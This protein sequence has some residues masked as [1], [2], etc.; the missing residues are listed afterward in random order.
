ML[1][2]PLE[3]VEKSIAQSIV[4]NNTFGQEK[5]FDD[6]ENVSKNSR[7][8][9]EIKEP[10]SFREE[11]N[12]N[13]LRDE[14]YYGTQ[15]TF[16]ASEIMNSSA[17]NNQNL[18][19]V[20]LS[21]S[22]AT[23]KNE[24]DIKISLIGRIQVRGIF[25]ETPMLI[26]ID[27]IPDGSSATQT[28]ISTGLS[29]TVKAIEATAINQPLNDSNV[30]STFDLLS[31]SERAN[32][33]ASDSLNTISNESWEVGNM[34]EVTMK[35]RDEFI[36]PLR[37][38]GKEGI[39]A[40][41]NPS[42]IKKRLDRNNAKSKSAKQVFPTDHSG[43]PDEERDA[44]SIGRVIS[45]RSGGTVGEPDS[46]SSASSVHFP[47]ILGSV[48]INNDSLKEPR[49][50]TDVPTI[51]TNRSNSIE[52]NPP[53]ATLHIVPL[54]HISIEKPRDNLANGGS[55]GTTCCP[56]EDPR[57]ATFG[58]CYG[59]PATVRK[60]EI[61]TATSR[62]LQTSSDYRDGDSAATFLRFYET[63][64][65]DR[66]AVTM[67]SSSPSTRLQ[68]GGDALEAAGAECTTN[69]TRSTATPD[70]CND[71]S[72]N[73]I[74]MRNTM[75]IVRFLTKLLRIVAEDE[76]PPCPEARIGDTVIHVKNVIINASSHVGRHK[77]ATDRTVIKSGGT[78]QDEL[79]TAEWRSAITERTRE[80]SS[81]P[82]SDGTFES[83][84]ETSTLPTFSDEVS[85][86][87]GLSTALFDTSTG[88]EVY[89]STSSSTAPSATPKS[90][91]FYEPA[92]KS[93]RKGAS[94]KNTGVELTG[95][96]Q[97]SSVP[98]KGSKDMPGE[99]ES[100][101]DGGQTNRSSS[102]VQDRGSVDRR[103]FGKQGIAPTTNA[104]DKIESFQ[105]KYLAR[106]RNVGSESTSVANGIVK[107]TLPRDI[108][109]SRDASLERIGA[110]RENKRERAKSKRAGKA[111][112]VSDRRAET[113]TKL[114]NRSTRGGPPGDWIGEHWAVTRRLPID[115]KL[116]E[117]RKVPGGTAT[118]GKVVF[119]RVRGKINR[120]PD[121][122]LVSGGSDSF[123][124]EGNVAGNG[125]LA[126]LSTDDAL[127]AA[128]GGG[129][130]SF[131]R[132]DIS[133]N[134]IRYSSTSSLMSDNVGT[135]NIDKGI[136]N[137]HKS[138][139][140][141]KRDVSESR[142]FWRGIRVPRK[143]QKATSPTRRKTKRRRKKKRKKGSQRTKD[144]S[145][146]ENQRRFKRHLLMA[147]FE[148]EYDADD[149]AAR[150]SRRRVAA[151]RRN[152]EN[153]RMRA[154]NNA[155]KRRRRRR[156]RER[157]GSRTVDGS[158]EADPGSTAQIR[159]GQD[160]TDRRHPPNIDAPK[161]LESAHCLRFSDLW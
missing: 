87:E 139:P 49:C 131:E 137:E 54:V 140:N 2:D 109:I 63:T 27:A 32:D 100:Q 23:S 44:T 3:T 69:E 145:E 79:T 53:N 103:Q 112:V 96:K 4:D 88:E 30:V 22:S 78:R 132:K 29:N 151:G 147:S 75:A 40:K 17:M 155:A 92:R 60:L 21:Q 55:I 19:N 116:R 113:R 15:P 24:G 159:G 101:L 28:S 118:P 117:S 14:S 42:Q 8:Y 119:R 148:P 138:I 20:D 124:I 82:L 46:R 13:N 50:R 10:F 12:E 36:D 72:V 70:K 144:I 130:S 102:R 61:T 97:N 34:D 150:F 156:R 110:T 98:F 158:E 122:N 111:V 84:A 160:C 105:E 83:F 74:R 143:E 52:I 128:V 104:V 37:G 80:K 26:S 33:E 129:L 95:V 94:R 56:R 47:D 114:L 121:P 115:K 120:P 25:N 153:I 66:N 133:E 161:Y 81:S 43:E 7:Y 85:K 59:M 136:A 41:K 125:P 152:A 149:A 51:E 48:L 107:P 89:A 9:E 146:T 64:V 58:G 91:L 62:E 134:A 141:K 45:A 18:S 99:K 57:N 106:S 86:D 65:N 73:A 68:N 76:E 11:I 5:S 154:G 126:K 31:I 135:S 16:D 108:D 1:E 142:D 38:S 71:E 39:A 157:D 35:S 127:S 90:F 93:L 67:S 6:S 77:S 123:K